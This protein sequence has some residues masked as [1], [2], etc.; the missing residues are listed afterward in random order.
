MMNLTL[1]GN[2][3]TSPALKLADRQNIAVAATMTAFKTFAVVAETL[4]SQ[5]L[6]IAFRLL[7]N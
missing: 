7:T 1:T 4:F 6:N 5:G 3:G 2:P